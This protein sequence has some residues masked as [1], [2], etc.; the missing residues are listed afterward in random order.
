MRKRRS[1]GAR[2]LKSQVF[3]PKPGTTVPGR[4]SWPCGAAGAAYGLD[5]L[6]QRDS[7]AVAAAQ[8]FDVQPE[9][10]RGASPTCCS[11]MDLGDLGTLLP[12]LPYDD[13]S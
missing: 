12:D 8:A 2:A 6:G 13:R 4:I 7:G 9:E 3:R 11:L 1:L 10:W 5:R